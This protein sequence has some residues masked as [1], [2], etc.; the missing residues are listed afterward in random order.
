MTDQDIK[1]RAALASD[2]PFL[3][4]VEQSA[5]VVFK[6]VPELQFIAADAPLSIDTLVEYL[7]SH[8]L[9]VAVRKDETGLD[10][11]VAFLAAKCINAEPFQ[12]DQS[13][14]KNEKRCKHLYIAECSVHSSYQRR[15]I[16][17]QLLA[18]VAE[19]ARKEEYDY[20]TLITF[21][22]ILW[23]GK[24]YTKH[25]FE[26]VKS[27]VIGHQYIQILEEESRQWSGVWR[28]EMQRRG[29]M[30]RKLRGFV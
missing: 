17:G 24:F 21:L 20:L 4:A 26:E 15:G 23:N 6:S 25:G 22:D 7:S 12:D 2:I 8:G 9:W 10:V 30:A 29:V 11:P 18:T 1:I 14:I 5:S 13:D 27:E 28:P 3:P 19:Y 16:A